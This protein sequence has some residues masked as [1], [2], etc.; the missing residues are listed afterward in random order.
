MK[1]IAEKEG[2]APKIIAS[3]D[4]NHAIINQDGLDLPAF[5]EHRIETKSVQ[6]FA[7]ATPATPKDLVGLECDILILGAGQGDIT[8]ANAGSIKAKL[9]VELAN[10]PIT[11]TADAILAA[12]NIPVV[13]DILANAGSIVV[14]Y[15]EWVQGLQEFFWTEREVNIELERI[16]Q[17]SFDE[18]EAIAKSRNIQLRTAAY[19]LAVERVANAMAVR[20]IYP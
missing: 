18:I 4:D 12:K 3:S 10:G 17:R 20:G 5:F 2:V 14:S 11:P 1:D 13:P 16:M 8:G 15:F 9:V 7:D 6:G 19:L